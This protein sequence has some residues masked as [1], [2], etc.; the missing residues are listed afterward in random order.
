MVRVLELGLAVDPAV[1]PDVDGPARAGELDRLGDRHPRSC[2]QEAADTLARAG[3]T[4]DR[5]RAAERDEAGDQDQEGIHGRDDRTRARRRPGG[6]RGHVPALGCERGS[7]PGHGRA[8]RNLP[9]TWA[10]MRSRPLV[11][12][13]PSGLPPTLR[14]SRPPRQPPLST[15]FAPR[16][17]VIH[18]ASTVPRRGRRAVRSPRAR[19]RIEGIELPGV[20]R[21]DEPAPDELGGGHDV[22][23]GDPPGHAPVGLD[24]ERLELALEEDVPEPRRG[25]DGEDGR[26]GA[27]DPA[28]VAGRGVEPVGVEAVLDDEER[29]R[30]PVDRRRLVV[31]RRGEASGPGPAA[32]RPPGARRGNGRR[33]RRPRAARGR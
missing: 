19:R 18:P 6:P 7:G 30:V 13:S 17:W 3:R 2:R 29:R 10:L 9:D 28:K 25:Q 31:E 16:R 24:R 33:G 20:A 32:A 11:S 27:V 22:G 23:V 14:A 5:S 12:L 8:R 1:D 15:R 26:R 21:Q 4:G